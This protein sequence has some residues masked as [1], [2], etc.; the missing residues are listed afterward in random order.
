MKK[1][2][3]LLAAMLLSAPAFTQEKSNL[4]VFSDEPEPFFVYVNGIRQ[5][6]KAETNVK[7]TGLSP[8]NSVRIVFENKALPEL[9]KTMMLEPGFEFSARIRRDKNGSMKLQP[10]GQVALSEGRNDVPSVTYHTSEN[11]APAQDV[12][13]TQVSTT[14]RTE[15]AP[16]GQVSN[17]ENVSVNVNMAGVGISMNVTGMESQVQST[18][19]TTVTTTSS[20]QGMSSQA[21]VSEPAQPVSSS[22]CTSPMTA[23]SFSTMKKSVES[24]PFS[25][26]K[27]STAKV[28]TKNNCLSVNQVKEI[29]KLFPMDDDKLAYAK[30]AYDYCV[31]KGNYYQVSEVFAFSSTTEEF[32]KFL[33]Q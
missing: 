2:L 27:M 13:T 4:V 17:S 3:L 25:D 22:G 14:T 12:T 19:S 30:Y 26:T 16:Q 18:S 28:A 32:N 20:S 10:F 11:V 1:C 24:K 23:S 6:D 15:A 21:A 29:C 8:N 9:K 5:N 7:V 31:E 33:E